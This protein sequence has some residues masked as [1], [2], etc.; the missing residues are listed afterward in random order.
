MVIAFLALWFVHAFYAAGWI[1]APMGNSILDLTVRLADERTITID[2]YRGNTVEAATHDGRVYSG[3]PPGAS[4][5]ALPLYFVAKPALSLVPERWNQKATEMTTG[6]ID[7]A[8]SPRRAEIMILAL[9]FVVFML[10]PAAAGTVLLFHAI[11]ARAWGDRVSR[12]SLLLGTVFFAFAT[13]H[14]YYAANVEHRS[15]SGL[16]LVGAFWLLLRETDEA[17]ASWRAPVAGLLLGIAVTITSDAAIIGVLVVAFCARRLGRR[18]GW[19]ALGAVPPLALLAAYNVAAFGSPL[20]SGYA[21]RADPTGAPPLFTHGMDLGWHPSRIARYLLGT[22][23][24]LFFYSPVLLLAL[25]PLVRRRAPHLVRFGWLVVAVMLAF[26]YAT[27]YE[28]LPGEFGFR[29]MTATLPFAALGL[30][31]GIEAIRPRWITYGLG[32]F[33]FLVVFRGVMW[34]LDARGF[35]LLGPLQRW[36]LPTYVLRQA[37]DHLSSI[38]PAVLTAVHAAGLAVLAFVVRAIFRPRPKT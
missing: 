24:G 29:L 22:R 3:M 30:A 33:S 35:A 9:L 6:E 5:L 11:A 36:G 17:R 10:A 18:L 28:G 1:A 12:R 27:G 38:G 26:H 19:V 21:F 31:G 32:A 2:P 23:H 14:F 37:S 8:P 4:V 13:T 20:A 7:V 25:V 16:A 34:G 15:L